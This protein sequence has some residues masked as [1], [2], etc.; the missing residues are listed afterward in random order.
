[1]TPEQQEAL[2]TNMYTDIFQNADLDKLKTYFSDDFV[3]DNNYDV[4]DY[5]TFVEHVKDIGSHPDKAKFDLE[6]IVNV[7]GKVV[8]RTIV[9]YADQIAGSPPLSLLMSYWAIN[10]QGLVSRCIEVEAATETE[11]D[12][13]D[14]QS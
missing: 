5:K 13:T 1:M 12:T 2:I 9:T 6:F 10:E 11:D 8:V 3:E 14:D 4:L 7:P